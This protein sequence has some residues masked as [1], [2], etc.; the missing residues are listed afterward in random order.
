M[1]H[2]VS[3][4]FIDQTLKKTPDNIVRKF[5]LASSD[6][7]DYVM[8]WPKFKNE[9]DKL[10]PSQM[11]I[12][13]A[14]ENRTFNFLKDDKLVL[15]SE[16]ELQFGYTHPQSGDELISLFLGKTDN[17]KYSREIVDL[18]ILDKF[19]Q[20]TERVVGS[21][22][23]PVEFVG[24]DYLPADIVW[25]LI[26][27]YG[28]LDTTKSAA[29][30][31]IE[32]DAWLAWWDVFSADS[33]FMNA[34]FDG[35]KVNEC[36]R[37]IG[38][39]TYSAIFVHENKLTFD[40]FTLADTY[41]N[42]FNDSSI[43][44]LRLEFSGHDIINKQYI[45]ADYDQTS[46]F[47]QTTV[48]TER[49]S[50][51]NSYGLRENNE[52]DENIWYVGSGPALNASQRVIAVQAEPEDK[53][54]FTAP[55]MGLIR[56]IGE[57]VTVVDTFHGIDGSYRVMAEQFDTDKGLITLNADRSQVFGAFILDTSTLDS[58]AVLI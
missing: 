38:R 23:E 33:V 5:L 49:T 56:L 41:V 37:K 31:D 44:D 7:S 26:T 25:W 53:I 50:S 32:Y 8:K 12:Q 28:G 30:V 51:I 1:S 43:L 10:R 2:Q 22:D 34:S 20:L 55:L 6:Y 14:N 48:F 54:E 29:N 21:S 57:T 46:D 13:L 9:W 4:W 45:F 42:S 3:S 24:S 16:A 40:R 36:V 27:S 35:Q 52:K 58:T 11:T 19:K 15:N 39:H 17:V 18:T 47:H